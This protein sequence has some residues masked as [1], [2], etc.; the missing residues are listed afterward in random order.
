MTSLLNPSKKRYVT[1][2]FPPAG[3]RLLLACATLM[4]ASCGI[5]G[6]WMNGDPSVGRNIVPPRDHWQKAGNDPAARSADWL[7]CGGADSGGYNV[8]TSDGSSSAV[9]QQAMSR[10]FDDMQRCMMSRG[11]HYTGSCEG[12]IRS[13]YPACQK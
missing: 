10:K 5:G 8:A 3:N 11:Y 4:L 2:S 9:I 7:G 1:M 13:Q 12:D 6:M